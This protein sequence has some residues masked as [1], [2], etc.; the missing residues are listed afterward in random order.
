M[1]NLRIMFLIFSC[2]FFLFILGCSKKAVINQID[3][4]NNQINSFEMK[5][6]EKSC[7]FERKDLG[8]K[9]LYTIQ[10]VDGKTVVTFDK[11]VH[12]SF[13]FLPGAIAQGMADIKTE[14]QNKKVKS[15]E[16]EID[17]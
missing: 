12:G 6:I 17:R 13:Y 11:E 4:K 2:S 15:A 3:A 7:E 16:T 1:V 10:E 9:P 14:C 8:S 5:F